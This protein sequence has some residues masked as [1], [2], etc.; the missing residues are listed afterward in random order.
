MPVDPAFR[1]P[2]RSS[3]VLRLGL[4]LALAAGVAI[5]GLVVRRPTHSAQPGPAAVKPGAGAGQRQAA[6]PAVVQAAR[7][8]LASP[9]AN[10]GAQ[11]GSTPAGRDRSDVSEI[12][13]SGSVLVI[14]ALH[15]RAPLVPT[16]AVGAPEAASLVIPADIHEVGWWDGTVRDSS[17]IVHE[18]APAPGQP[19]VAL[20]AGHVDSAAAGPGA[21]Y[22]LGDLIVGDR[23]EIYGS[24]SQL[25]LWVVDTRPQTT[26][27]AQLPPALWAT[28]GAPSLALV[29][30]GGPFDAATGH[31]ID[32]VIVW[33]R[34]LAAPKAR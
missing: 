8:T 22:R 19:G 17:H 10:A 2:G 9:A 21:L 34:Q 14:P 12:E 23:I 33:A 18:D 25:S 1:S 20:I 30:C 32:N 16:G 31:Y 15:V 29:T 6:L 5:A 28:T 7:G 27:K 11:P 26:P 3:R 4:V 13:A 24:A